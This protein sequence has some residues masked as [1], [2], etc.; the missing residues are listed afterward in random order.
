MNN[1]KQLIRNEKFTGVYYVHCTGQYM[2][3]VFQIN[4]IRQNIYV[5][6]EQ[7]IH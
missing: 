2:N 7:L 6:H 3:I 4:N 5:I 1:Y